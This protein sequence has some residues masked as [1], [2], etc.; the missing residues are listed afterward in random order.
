MVSRKR[1][2]PAPV[3]HNDAIDLLHRV[4]GL[5]DGGD[6][7]PLLVDVLLGKGAALSVLESL[8]GWATA[9]DGK[10]PELRLNAPEKLFVIDPCAPRQTA[11]RGRVM[12]SIYVVAAIVGKRLLCVHTL[13]FHQMQAEEA[14]TRQEEVREQLMVHRQQ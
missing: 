7:R 11:F 1:N 5:S 10:G 3:P 8:F 12:H 14:R 9:A 2:G 13:S 6:D 4:N